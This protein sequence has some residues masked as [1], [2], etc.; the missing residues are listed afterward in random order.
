MLSVLCHFCGET[1]TLSDD[2]CWD[3]PEIAIGVCSGCSLKQQ[4]DFTH[5]KEDYYSTGTNL[6]ADMAAERKRQ[7]EWNRKR[8][9][10]ILDSMPGV[11]N[12]KLLDYACGTGGFLEKAQGV[13]SS[14]TGF[15]LCADVC[16]RH[17]ASGWSCVS[18]LDDVPDDIGVITL[19]HV[20]E[21]IP[22]PWIILN[23]LQKKFRNART[24]VIEVP[25]TDEA[26][27]SLFMNSAYR[28]NHY[29][30]EHLWYF[31]SKTLRMLL[32]SAGLHIVVD[33][34]FQRYSLANTLGWLSNNRG[35]FQDAWEF[36]NDAQLNDHYERV[37]NKHK[38][39]DSLFM[40]CHPKGMP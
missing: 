39:A 28:I 8:I 2:R 26:L 19:F 32:E 34:Q 5:I 11:K 16:A 31:N 17:Q 30:A 22:Q 3:R 36:F 27:N 14:I 37:L 38:I 21:H 20:L 18:K 24:F 23:A 33:T 13:F 1:L 35:G 12:Q 9:N 4:F 10:L 6:P 7:Q 29:S 15:D 40:I 25:N